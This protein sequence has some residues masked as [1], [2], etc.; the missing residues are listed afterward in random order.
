MVTVTENSL[1]LSPELEQQLPAWRSALA[2]LKPQRAVGEAER[3]EGYWKLGRDIADMLAHEAPEGQR[4][5]AIHALAGRLEE[6]YATVHNLVNVGI[7]FH[8]GLL[9]QTWTWHVKQARHLRRLGERERLEQLGELRKLPRQSSRE[10][11]TRRS[12]RDDNARRRQLAEQLQAARA[13]VGILPPELRLDLVDDC[14]RGLSA[15][16]LDIPFAHES[17]ESVCEAALALKDRVPPNRGAPGP[18]GEASGDEPRT[19]S[20]S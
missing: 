7:V 1:S 14:L 13:A 17:V 6:S 8:G 4:T 20:G 5:A 19:T 10:I 15:D 12:A 9:E 3:A 16:D 11:P 18:V 2:A